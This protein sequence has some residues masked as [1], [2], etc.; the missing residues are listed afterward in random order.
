L[1]GL[2]AVQ[3]LQ[4]QQRARARVRVGLAEGGDG[5]AVERRRLVARLFG[6]VGL[7]V[8]GLAVA[9]PTFH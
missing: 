7:V 9:P 6:L 8:V 2:V 4:A 1:D 3:A 5:A